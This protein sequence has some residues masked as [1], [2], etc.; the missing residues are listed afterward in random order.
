MLL[1]GSFA[2]YGTWR[3]FITIGFTL[4]AWGVSF[5]W[6]GVEDPSKWQS[7]TALY[8]LGLIGYQCALTFWTA[9]FPGLARDLP[10][11]KESG[12]MLARGETE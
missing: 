8:I 4:L 9:A 6:L 10:E 7:G 12:H 1:V 11:I 5:G 2:D 3:P